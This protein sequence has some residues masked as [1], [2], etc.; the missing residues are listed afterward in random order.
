MRFGIINW[1]SIVPVALS[2]VSFVSVQSTEA[3]TSHHKKHCATKKHCTMNKKCCPAK[4]CVSHGKGKD[5]V[6]TAMADGS[7]KTLVA[8]LKAAGLVCVLEGAGPFTV[9]APDDAAF[10]KMGKATSTEKEKLAKVLKYHVVK[11][12][13]SAADLANMRS[14]TTLEG[15]SLMLDNKDGKEIVDGAL[16]TKGDIECSNGVIH[17]IDMVLSPERGK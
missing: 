7:F 9:F 15:E 3:A 13:H 10:G 16:V 4:K 1:A 11:G 14:I 2:L 17:V 5:I 8:D 12:K 6:Q